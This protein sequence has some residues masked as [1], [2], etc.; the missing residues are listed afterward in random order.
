M[1]YKQEIEK[2]GW[3]RWIRPKRKYYHIKCCDCGLKHKLEFKLEK[4]GKH[5]YIF[6]R[7][8]SLNHKNK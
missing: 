5:T 2:N 3:T 1:R 6:Y 8:K 7:A 4:H